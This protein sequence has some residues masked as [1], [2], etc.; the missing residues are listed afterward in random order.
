[1][2]LTDSEIQ[3][4]LDTV[5]PIEDWDRLIPGALDLPGRYPPPQWLD[6]HFA[7]MVD[8]LTARAVAAARDAG[9]TTPA[10]V[11]EHWERGK[12]RYGCK[13]HHVSAVAMGAA[14]VR[15][16]DRRIGQGGRITHETAAVLERAD[17]AVGR[18]FGY[19]DPELIGLWGGDELV[20]LGDGSTPERR[21]QD[22]RDGVKPT[23]AEMALLGDPMT[24]ANALRAALATPA[25]LEP[26]RT[27]SAQDEPNNAAARRGLIAHLILNGFDRHH[28]KGRIAASSSRIL[29]TLIAAGC[30]RGALA[31]VTTE[32]AVAP[33]LPR[34]AE[35]TAAALRLAAWADG[36]AS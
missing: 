31:L 6:A 29:F 5:E 26:L 35:W 20:T 25:D 7:E 15:W 10:A 36:V 19:D 28:T 30:D 17:A 32:P 21:A 24:L 22:L 2:T 3:H 13:S 34:S 14:I 1:M 23:D 12:R 27:I 11:R 4:I 18:R 33:E 16:N 8:N 9:Q